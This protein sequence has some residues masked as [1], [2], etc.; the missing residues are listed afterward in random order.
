[1]ATEVLSGVLDDL[2]ASLQP[3]IGESSRRESCI[4]LLDLA[5]SRSIA[6]AMSCTP[7]VSRVAPSERRRTRRIAGGE[8]TSLAGQEAR[9]EALDAHGLS[10]AFGAAARGRFMIRG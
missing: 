8:A 1:V 10:W 7:R 5:I 9:L 6:V 2:R 3:V 4:R